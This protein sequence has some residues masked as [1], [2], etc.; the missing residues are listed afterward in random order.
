MLVASLLPVQA[1]AAPPGDRTGVDLPGLQ[2][3][4]KAKL[5]AVEAA[6]LKGWA[7]EAASPPPAFEPKAL[8]PP[9][10]GSYDVTLT[11]DQPVRAGTLPVSIGKAEGTATA[12]SG[13]W[14]VAVESRPATEAAS[15]DG[16]LIKITPPAGASTPVDVKLDY[17]KFKDLYGTEW[18]SRLQLKQLPA[19]FLSTPDVPE[20]S[21]SKDLPSTNNPSEKTVVATVDPTTSA[22]AQ[23]LRTM[24]GSAGGAVVLAASDGAAGAGGSY[25]AT[26]LS[27]SGSW[28]AGGSG[29]GFS[30]NY[31]LTVPPAPAGPTPSIAFSY[32]SQAVDGKTSATNGQASWIGDGWDYNPGFIERRYRS[33]AD[34]RSAK[35]SK[36]NN[37]NATDKKKADLCWA[38]DNVVL[39][40]GGVTTALVHDDKTGKWVPA[41][42][43]G[44]TVERRTGG[45]NG[46][47]DGEYWVVTTRDGTRY[48]YGRHNVGAHGDG[49]TPQTATDSVFTVPVFGNHPGEPCYQASYA[50]SSC[51]QAWRWNLDYVE[52]VHG[53]AMVVDWKKEE[54]RYAR[55]EKF[56]E[57][58]RAKVGYVRGGYPVRILYGLRADNLAGAPAGRVEFEAKPRCFAE[59]DIK[60]GDAQ[61]NSK[62]AGDKH[63]W[64]DT[65]TTLHCTMDVPNCYTGAPTFW[66]NMRLAGISTYGQRTEGSTALSKVDQWSLD[67]SFPA[68]RTDTHPP[69][70]LKSITRTGYGVKDGAIGVSLPAVTFTANKNDMPNRVGKSA[71]EATP[72]FDRLR[73]ATIRTETGGEIQVNYSAPCPV[74]TSGLKPEGNTT[75]CFPVHWSPDPDLPPEKTPIE[76]FNKYV[77]DSVVETDRVALR[78]A[79]TTSYTYEG[80]AAWAK[81]DDEF[82]K[83]ELRTYSQWRGY[84][85]VLTTT[86]QTANAGT[87]TATEQS[88]TR[89]RYFRGLSREGAKVTVK[90]STGTEELGE[91]KPR[92]QGLTAETITY[93][94]AN[95]AVEN[96]HLTWPWDSGAATATRKRVD[97]TDLEAH[98]RG[99][100]RTDEIQSVSGGKSRMVRTRNDFETAYGLVKSTQT[101][102]MENKGTGWTTVDQSCNKT[103]YV[104]NAANNLIGLPAQVRTTA[105]DCTD[106]ATSTGTVLSAARTSFDAVNAFGAAPAKGLPY[107]VDALDAAGTGWTTAGRTEYDAL[108]R[109]VKAYDAAGNAAT[110]AFSPATGPTFATTVTNALGHTVTA[111]VD[112]AR[113]SVLETTDAN[114]RKVTTAY[115]ELG[116]STKVWT[117]S[118]KPATDRPAY[119]FEY[120]IEELKTPAVTSRSLKDDGTYTTSIAIYDGLLRPRQTQAEAPGGGRVI[121]DTLYSANGTVSQT[122]NGYHAEGRADTAIFVPQSLT[123][124]HNSTQTAYDGL[125][126]PVR[127]TT[128]QKGTPQQ[129]A[130]TQY[131]GDWTL[132]RSAMSPTGA[133]PLAGS[134]AVK[135]TTD[136]LNRTTL[137]EHYTSTHPA[138]VDPAK[139]SNPA[140]TKTQYTYDARGKLAK[141]TDP[142]GSNW[143]YAYD[144]RGRM[145][146]SDDPDMGKAT[147]TYDILDRQVSATDSRGLAQYTKYDVLGRKTALHDDSETG[148]VVATWTYDTLPGAKGQPVSATRNWGAGS[149]VSE[150]TGYDSEY[151]PTGSKITIP[152]LPSTKGLAGTYAYSTTYTPT[153]KVQSTTLPATIGGLA[154]EKLITRYNADGMVQTMSGLTWYTADTVYSPFGEVL[155]TASG[156]APHRV[157]TTNAYD[158]HTGRITETAGHR[159]TKDD[160][161]KS[162]LVSALTYAYDKV[163]NPTSITDTQPGG[164]ID[165]QCY[166]YDA[167]GRLTRAWTGKT[168]GCPTG[169][170][171]P[172]LTEVG[173]AA[174]GDAYWQDYEFD[175][176]GNRTKLTEHDLTNT[177]LDDVT[178]Y[179]YGVALKEGAGSPV[180]QP[181]AL[182]GVA[183]TAKTA[184][185]TVNSSSTYTY[186]AAGNTKTR[187]IDG[188]TQTLTWDRRNKLTSA[189][190]PGI[191]A[192]AITGLADKCLDVENGKTAEGT[193]VQLLSCN[194][195]KPQQWRIT[196]DTVQALGKCLTS[197]NGD[198]VL[199]TCDGRPEQ[200]FTYRAADKALY[201]GTNGCLTVPNDN[202]A[203]G[204][205]LDIY[206]CAGPA[207]T[208]AQ[209]WSFSN[210]TNYLHD[211]SGNRVIEETGS[212]RTL[213]LG[214]TEITV[215]KAGQAIDAV[216]YYGSPS[217]GPTTVRRTNGKA[218]GHTLS[219][220]LTDHHNTATT[221]IEQAPGQKDTR[222]KSDPYGNPRG[223]Q[224]SDWPGSHT[225]LGTGVDDNATALTHIGAREYEPATGRFISVDPIIDITDPLQMNGY[226]YSAGNPI[227]GSDPTGLRSE[228]CGTLYD[229]HG[230]S[231]ITFSNASTITYREPA[232]QRRYYQT[233][234]ETWHWYDRDIR[235]QIR[236]NEGIKPAPRNLRQVAKDA[237]GGLIG[238]LLRTGDMV[239][240]FTPVLARFG[241]S[242]GQVATRMSER[243]GLNEKSAAYQIAELFSP[244][245]GG[246][247]KTGAM[248]ARG[249][250]ARVFSKCNSFVAGAKVQLADGTSKPIEQ[251]AADDE[252]TATDPETGETGPK[253]VTATIYTTDD[254]KYVDVAIQTD[255]GVKT[256]TTTDHHPF[257][258]ESDQAWKDAG[259]L[260]PG[261]TLRTDDGTP[262]AVVQI[263]TYQ[264]VKETYNLTVADLHTYYVL[265]GATPVLVHNCPAGGAPRS[266][267]GKF[268]KRNGEPGRDGAA[269]E[270][271]AWDQLEM[272]GAVVMRNETAVS[273]PGMRVRKYDGTVEI[274]GQWYGIEVKGGTAK[275][276]PQQR[277]FDDW[278]NTPGNTVT[279]SDG[280]TLVGVHDVWIDR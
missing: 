3:D 267:D 234:G 196:G 22:P 60:C 161:T 103:T 201:T 188:D 106:A 244:G 197:E 128:L 80:G 236:K 25:K 28:T 189:T 204:N 155:R 82:T 140:T 42:D 56:S 6:K 162:N 17:T 159:E 271:N 66:S 172:A 248:A 132:T 214:E 71:N 235:K 240:P 217:G 39:S 70:W 121:A 133:T 13:T 27:P 242:G 90:D 81:E 239:N 195:T 72:D 52:D 129:S 96:R 46:A 259:D 150:V 137:V 166:T 174:P 151:R 115:D 176:V 110:T 243:F 190:S 251:L 205:D 53:N 102:V 144:A 109:A 97:T 104:H 44:S 179:G 32:S 123:E 222:R 177:A 233:A 65:P 277:E 139:D 78:P 98:R 43:D 77:V 131:G 215:N 187:R 29:G 142:A 221:S 262:A 148:P 135:T 246:K 149:Y 145:T 154:A 33:C 79:V 212:A 186:D 23:G 21:V 247:A 228:E 120:Q 1:W 99:V 181:H 252:V 237:V 183:K 147:F 124:I 59:G 178:T 171:G 229:C 250:F 254:K 198:A 193:A 211:A 55:N 238:G 114:G 220:L 180:K 75:R 111:K 200:K 158:T 164:R 160:L 232:A 202:A 184:T 2:K 169:S 192:V 245:F 263:R 94:K 194:E 241:M 26:S 8:A 261:T 168:E 19:C 274:N 152:S 84:A 47:K 130:L 253:A 113:G 141:V 265:A 89:T 173:S 206:P 95:G 199:R 266:A 30:W 276:N 278:L 143:T 249:L 31:P 255:D 272:D 69:L 10:A 50:N 260:K 230:S 9:A 210:T 257:W 175:A 11:G 37:D 269:D 86:G 40:F 63:G 279:T 112:P 54:N 191:G 208:A 223:A 35:I 231:V 219:I 58:D 15:V 182:T 207:P 16:A 49:S 101:D 57:K 117:P 5:D 134:R 91:D 122:N 12:P 136:A 264:D 24:T 273:A 163:G 138:D 165:R 107:Q 275:K 225:F 268:S 125:G 126:R 108:G 48:H 68:Q 20:C 51:T 270:A 34:D 38:G 170:N 87:P 227:T 88:Q 67:Q 18:S 45:S 213:Y 92:Y 105:G 85:G 76:W 61:F 226:T 146:S 119:T 73:I 256:I 153:G 167:I 280:R 36:P 93:A 127:T 157:W 216:R 4:L 14:N 224:P 118:Q 116:R 7:G 203:E 83:P 100:A 41:A 209:Q 258:S 74:G 62:N 64:W 156:A 218:T 185:S